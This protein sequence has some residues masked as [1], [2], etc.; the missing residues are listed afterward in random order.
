MKFSLDKG[1]TTYGELL[2]AQ[3]QFEAVQH[4]N[5]NLI[6]GASLHFV[7]VFTGVLYN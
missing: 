4:L 7:R 5:N 6:I 3:D 2:Y 1:Q